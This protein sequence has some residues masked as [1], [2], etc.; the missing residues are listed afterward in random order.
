MKIDDA[1]KM[2]QEAKE[3]GSNNII[4]AFWTCDVFT[5][6]NDK[7]LTKQFTENK[8]WENIVNF[9]DNN[10]DWSYTHDALQEIINEIR[11]KQ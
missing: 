7:G 6:V 3:N 8:V 11:V 4:F 2:L 5:K 9:I 10:M 1:I